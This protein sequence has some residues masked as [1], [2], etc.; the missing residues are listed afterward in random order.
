MQIGVISDTHGLVR[1]NA[2][3]ALR[4]VDLIIHAGDVGAASV[5][6]RLGEIAPVYAVRGN[7]DR[8][9]WALKLPMTNSCDAGSRHIYVIHDLNK[10]DIEPKAAGIDF[11]IFGHTHRPSLEISGGLTYLN[12]GSAGQRRFGL[13]LSVA[14]LTI[15]GPENHIALYDLDKNERI[16]FK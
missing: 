16:P 12:P 11:L 3:Y 15:A 7:C 6:E 5:L 2:I 1:E 10:L 8:G 4:G 9:E 13:P 14:V